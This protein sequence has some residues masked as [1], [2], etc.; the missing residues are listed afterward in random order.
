[1]A[2]VIILPLI[3]H[4]KRFKGVVSCQS[5]LW[6]GLTASLFN[7]SSLSSLFSADLQWR[8]ASTL[9]RWL[10][11]PQEQLDALRE[12]G[13]FPGRTEPGGLPERSRHLLLH[14]P[15]CGVQAGA[16]GVVQPGVRPET[17][18]PAGWAQTQ[19]VLIT[20]HL[21]APQQTRWLYRNVKYNN[22]RSYFI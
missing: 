5:W 15:T 10:W 8:A 2:Q 14:H 3:Q 11:C 22:Y 13:S 4:I 7:P 1:M 21:E 6:L 19:W 16:A 9:H 20:E 12:P 17:L 18:Q